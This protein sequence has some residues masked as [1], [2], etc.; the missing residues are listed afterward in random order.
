MGAV[1][2]ELD[3]NMSMVGASSVHGGQ[4][5]EKGDMGESRGRAGE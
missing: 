3:Q 1:S 5:E 2:L 4:N